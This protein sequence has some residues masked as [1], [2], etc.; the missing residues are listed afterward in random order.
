MHRGP[1]DLP[2]NASSSYGR[3]PERFDARFSTGSPELAGTPTQ[4][5]LVSRTETQRR[6]PRARW[7]AV[8]A[9]TTR[10]V[11]VVNLGDDR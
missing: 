1:V 10:D 4:W 6:G 8:T 3:P 2:L 7:G 11:V 9:A 5:S